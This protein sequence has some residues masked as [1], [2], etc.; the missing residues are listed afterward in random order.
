MIYVLNKIITKIKKVYKSAA[1][2]DKNNKVNTD[3]DQAISNNYYANIYK[4]NLLVQNIAIDD[5]FFTHYFPYEENINNIN[6]GLY[7]D[8]FINSNNDEYIFELQVKKISAKADEEISQQFDNL[9]NQT[10]YSLQQQIEAFDKFEDN[11]FNKYILSV[12]LIFKNRLY[13]KAL[14]KYFTKN[15]SVNEIKQYGMRL[16]NHLKNIYK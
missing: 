5:I 3:I 8:S 10:Q 16:I 9:F 13:Y 11:K 12:V 6:I 2:L 1:Y 15:T 14:A 7:G 4:K